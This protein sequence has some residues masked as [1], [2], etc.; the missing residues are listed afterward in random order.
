MIGEESVS[1]V[2]QAFIESE[3]FKLCRRW[4]KGKFYG[5]EKN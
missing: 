1:N 4:Q 5:I 2:L 3:N